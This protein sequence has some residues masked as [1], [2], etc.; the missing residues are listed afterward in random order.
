MIMAF[1][2]RH[3]RFESSDDRIAAVSMH[4]WSF[5]SLIASLH[6]HLPCGR[7]QT[8]QPQQV[9]GGTDEM[10]VQLHSS[11]APKARAT[12]SAP[13]LHPA[14]DLL[15]PLTL[16]LTDPVALVA[17]RARIEPGGVAT[18]NL[19]N[20]RADALAAQ[21]ADEGLA[22]IALVR[23]EA[24][25]PQALA[26]LAL[27]KLASRTRLSL[28]RRAHADVH[29]KPVAVLHQCMTAEG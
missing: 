10:R 18:L 14:E 7:S 15:D 8:T 9:V 22:V 17:R 16:S 27:E 2:A 3:E 20:V 11:D 6:R 24:R 1:L 19:R 21:K 23:P 4:L 5:S 26:P 13:G 25:G 28:K 29:A 12:K